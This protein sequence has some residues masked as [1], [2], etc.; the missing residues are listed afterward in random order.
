VPRDSEVVLG[1]NDAQENNILS[2]LENAENIILIDYEY[3]GWAPRAM[4]LA[5]YFNETMLDNDYPLKNGIGYYLN[6]FINDYE[7]DIV[8][9]TYLDTY[10]DKYF[11][12]DKSRISKE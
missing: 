1:H 5:N 2:S 11:K 10:Y 3:T 9:T 7:Q 6:N 8:I 4:D 12:G